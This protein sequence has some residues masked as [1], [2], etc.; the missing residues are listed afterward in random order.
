MMELLRARAQ[1]YATA[2]WTS[3]ESDYVAANNIVPEAVN[4]HAGLLA[5]LPCCFDGRGYFSFDGE[6][7]HMA[8]VIEAYDEDAETP[9]DLV[10]W[11]IDK[12]AAFATAVGFGAL[13][14]DQV[15]NPATYA[16][17]GKLLIHRTPLNWLKSGCKGVVVLH[18]EH[19]GCWLREALGNILAED[20]EHARQLASWI[21]PKP[22][23]RKRIL[24]PRK[25]EGR[26][27]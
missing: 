2:A 24:Y 14:I 15:T 18:H 10:A 19:A 5:I 25:A 6:R 1:L 11:P 12:P 7:L 3:T 21:N 13:G 17:G 8:A 27:A 4:A 26:A 9:A 20:E 16:F 22:F 23:D